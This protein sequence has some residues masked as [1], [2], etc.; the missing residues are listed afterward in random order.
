MVIIK[1]TVFKFL[2]VEHFLRNRYAICSKK[3]HIWTFI[4]LLILE[5]CYAV[6][7]R[8]L[9]L[10]T[11]QKQRVHK[12]EYTPKLINGLPRTPTEM[13]NYL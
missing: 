9:F 3:P 8:D 6:D 5:H 4:K 7:A 11:P 1:I 2:H 12:T 10:K 13:E